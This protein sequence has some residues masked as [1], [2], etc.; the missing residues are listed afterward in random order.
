MDFFQITGE[1]P[2]TMLSMLD[3]EWHD[4]AYVL[5]PE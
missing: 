2:E 5:C 4:N 3:G 1:T